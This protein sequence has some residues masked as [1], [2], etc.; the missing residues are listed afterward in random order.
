MAEDPRHVIKNDNSEDSELSENEEKNLD[1][2]LS[3]F[4]VR[5]K[6][7]QEDIVEN[8]T[9]DKVR[10]ILTCPICLELYKDLVLVRECMHRFCR[11]CIEKIIRG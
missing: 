3:I 10:N 4:P 8:K 2:I 7:H 11:S 6:Y 1:T 9:F 5:T